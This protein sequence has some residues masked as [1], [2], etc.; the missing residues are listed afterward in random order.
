MEI[1]GVNRLP[2]LPQILWRRQPCPLCGSVQFKQAEPGVLDGL[3]GMGFAATSALRQ[4]LA[5]VLQVCPQAMTGALF[6]SASTT[7]P[8]PRPDRTRLQN[9]SH[10]DTPLISK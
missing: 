9:A 8:Q 6:R 2:R 4:L 3:L 10:L 5:A 7:R 1:T